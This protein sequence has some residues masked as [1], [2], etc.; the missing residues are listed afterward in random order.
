MLVAVPAWAQSTPPTAGTAP[1]GTA[2]TATAHQWRHDR[3]EP[4]RDDPGPAAHASSAMG[5]RSG[6]SL[7]EHGRPAH[8]PTAYP[9]CTLRRQ[10]SSQW[11]QFTQVMRD[12][13]KAMD[14]MYQSGRKS[15]PACR[16]S[17]T[18][19][20]SRRIEQARA[21]GMQKLVPAF[22][23]LYASLSDQQKQRLMRCSAIRRR[24]LRPTSRLPPPIR[25]NCYPRG[26]HGVHRNICS[27]ALCVDL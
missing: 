16:R 8:H 1:S 12:N 25:D 4:C 5:R 10:Q 26:P 21:D 20:R 7:E 3:V 22:Q 9:D 18:C 6:E 14:Q 24:R 17:T 19:S 11:D 27:V 13:A 2:P 23:T 15:C